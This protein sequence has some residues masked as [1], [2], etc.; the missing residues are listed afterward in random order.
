MKKPVITNLGV[1]VLAAVLVC[2][3]QSPGGPSDE[4]LINTAMTDWKAAMAARDLDKIMAAYSE[5]YVSVRGG[6]K[7]SMRGF[8]KGAIERGLMDNVK[9]NLEKAETTV[10]QDKAEF[11]PVEFVSERGTFAVRYTLQKETGTWLIVTTKRQ[12][13]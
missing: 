11:G 6:G 2:G 1:A 4:K 8:I 7:D 5:N 10:E 13:Q 3:C 9:V 12:E